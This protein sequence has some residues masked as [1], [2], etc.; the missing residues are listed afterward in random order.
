MKV[1]YFIQLTLTE[2]ECIA[3][4]KVLGNINDTDYLDKFGLTAEELPLMS[5]ICSVVPDME[6]END[7]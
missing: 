6:E 4:K 5:A 1:E 2:A 7:S 3:L